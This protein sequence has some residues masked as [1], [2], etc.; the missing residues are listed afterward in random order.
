MATIVLFSVLPIQLSLSPVPRV[1]VTPHHIWTYFLACVQ[2]VPNYYLVIP[3]CL[4][5][6]NPSVSVMVASSSNPFL[7]LYLPHSSYPW[8]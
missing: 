3:L 2:A 5:Y 6:L 8:F 7:Y 1:S 4:Y